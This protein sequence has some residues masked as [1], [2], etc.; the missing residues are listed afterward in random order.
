MMDDIR[1]Q[2]EFLKISGSV[3][4]MGFAEKIAG[5]LEKLLAV[6]EAAQEQLVMLDGI[7]ST[8]KYI[9]L[10]K[11][12]AAAQT[13]EQD[14]RPY[15]ER[16]PEQY[17]VNCG[18]WMCGGTACCDNPKGPIQTTEQERG[19]MG[20]TPDDAQFGDGYGGD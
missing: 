17:C 13:T 19:Q 6:L 8:A 5:S 20:Y 1:E 11:A 15:K 3:L 10:I 2:I 16:F 9:G 12:I 7:D 14:K 4:P 18:Q